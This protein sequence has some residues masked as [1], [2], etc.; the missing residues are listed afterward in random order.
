MLA[1]SLRSSQMYAVG[2]SNIDIAYARSRGIVVTITGRPDRI[3]G[4][5]HVGDD[6]GNHT[7]P[8]RRRTSPSAG[9]WKGWALDFMLRDGIERQEQLGLVGF[10]AA[11][12]EPLPRGRPPSACGRHTLM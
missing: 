11:S 9:D 10:G 6:S 3:G 2:F 5:L 7:P 8:G 12:R 1:P 4:R